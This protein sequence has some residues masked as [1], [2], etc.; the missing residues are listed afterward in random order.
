VTSTGKS[1]NF[2]EDIKN[3]LFENKIVNFK[4]KNLQTKKTEGSSQVGNWTRNND[5]IS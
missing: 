1:S 4:E 3:L 5:F 2:L